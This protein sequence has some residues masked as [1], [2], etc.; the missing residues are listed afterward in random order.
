MKKN[1]KTKYAILGVLSMAP[2]SGY[3]IKKFCDF[4]I[5]HF[6]NENYAHL[7]PV[8]KELEEE[9]LVTSTQEK[10]SGRPA[11]SIYS[12]TAEGRQELAE[13]LETPVEYGP[14]RHELLLKLFFSGEVPKQRI[15]EVLENYKAKLSGNLGSYLEIEDKLESQE[16]IKN[17]RGL[18]LWLATVRFGKAQA[19]AGIQWCDETIEAVKGMKDE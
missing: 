12:I 6:W 5:A 7:Y 1:N 15:I 13:W 9:A 14:G 2:G 10:S 19:A 3:D 17:Q 8:L 11:K 4:S 16:D 18:P